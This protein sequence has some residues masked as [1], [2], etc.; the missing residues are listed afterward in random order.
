MAT[1]KSSGKERPSYRCT[2]CGWTTAKWLGRC[3]EC[4]AWGT[5]E[6]FG[7]A[8]AVRTTAPGRVTTAAVPIGQV[9]G[10]QATARSTGVPELDRVLGG[11]LVPGAVALVAGEPGVGKSTL[12]LDVAA[13]AAS[14][15]HRT[16]YVTG[17]ESASQ[18]RLRADRIGALDDHLYL[19]A[20]TDLSAVLGHLDT[21]KPSL[22]I[23]DSV[24]TV[25][26]PEIEGA[27]GGMAQVREVAGALI[28]ASKDRGMATLLVGHV[29][30]DGAI[31]GPRLLEHLVD[32]VLHFEGDRHARLRLVRGVKNRYGTTDEVGCF[33]LHDEGITGLTDPSGLFLTRR[34]EPV[35][36][37]CLTVTLEGRRPLVAEV[38]AL[39]VDSQIPS[40]RRTTSG[41][42][43]SRVSMMLA[44][45]EQ[46]GRI[47][48]L[49]KRDIYSATVGGVK[50]TEP[51]ADLAVALALASA[52][53]DTPLPKNLVAIGE[54]GLA[55][56]VRRVTGVQRRLSE[57]ARLGFTHALVPAD[58]GK[59]PD[60][61]RVLEVADVGQA[62]SV[63]PKR[64]RREAPQEEG[65]RR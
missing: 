2:E 63:L 39:T 14:D 5:V 60:G 22:L 9:D 54:V 40:P 50:L 58:P 1:R 11:G 27:P 18:V 13:K 53:S 4:Q 49:G 7:G 57:A 19:A 51:A 32:V 59:I 55:G 35:P 31:A 23:L 64:V 21:V 46:R 33:E 52:A 28:R 42:E 15:A 16:L 3:P 8:P 17:E 36:G 20:E 62:L 29:T 37:T 34:A 30:K 26:S 10:K 38:Q 41:L 25:A 61:M 44:V 56:E 65:A 24:Q 45:L 48:A 43:T 12:L 6:E 47:S